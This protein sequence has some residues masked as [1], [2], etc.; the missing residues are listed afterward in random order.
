MKEPNYLIVYNWTIIKIT[1]VC[2]IKK[3]PKEDLVT[4]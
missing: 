4:L 1:I 3:T 2:N